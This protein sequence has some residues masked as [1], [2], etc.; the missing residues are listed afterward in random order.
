MKNLLVVGIIITSIALVTGC[1]EGD[2]ED[3]KN[4]EIQSKTDTQSNNNNVEIENPE[5]LVP[6][7]EDNS[8]Q[9]ENNENQMH[10]QEN[11]NAEGISEENQTTVEE[12]T[13]KDEQMEIIEGKYVGQIDSNSIEVKIKDPQSSEYIFKS[14]RL[15]NEVKEKF[16]TYSLDEGDNVRIKYNIEQNEASIIY[17]IDKIN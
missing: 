1:S 12:D 2:V 15:S 7:G 6:V 17:Q 9:Y 10:E 4:N 16:S 11:G 13:Y 3:Y 5:N 8:G 14:F